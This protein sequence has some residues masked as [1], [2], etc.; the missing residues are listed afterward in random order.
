MVTLTGRGD[1]PTYKS[2]KN[3]Y[4]AGVT[5][6]KSPLNFATISQHV[7]SVHNPKTQKFNNLKNTTTTKKGYDFERQIDIMNGK[8]RGDKLE[9]KHLEGV[10]D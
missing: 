3:L 1:N 5:K 10:P 4:F 6:S 2:Y 7:F 9:W 8:Y